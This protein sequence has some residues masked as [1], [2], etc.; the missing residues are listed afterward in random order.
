M[1][2]DFDIYRMFDSGAGSTNL[3]DDWR[4]IARGFHRNGVDMSYANKL[5]VYGDSSGRQVKVPTGRVW[6]DGFYGELTGEKTLAVTTNTSGST[7]YDWVV[8]RL[9]PTDN[10]V[11][12][13]VLVGT[14]NQ[15][16]PALTQS[17]TGIYEIALARLT[18]TNNYTTIAAADVLDT[19]PV[20]VGP[21]NSSPWQMIGRN[22]LASA[23]DT[24]SVTFPVRKFLKVVFYLI[25]T[26]G[27]IDPE[28]TVNGDG[29]GNYARRSS[30]NGAAEDT[31]TSDTNIDIFSSAVAEPSLG[32]LYISNFRT[33][34]KIITGHVVREGTSAASTSPDRMEIVAKWVTATEQIKSLSFTNGGGAGDYAIGSDVMVFGHD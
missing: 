30:I 31:A 21:S 33:Q 34:A 13:D 11:Q 6:V 23:G 27:T 9:N 2:T 3:E 26:G 18:L 32:V 8:A 1:A 16:T 15:D 17:A 28:F 12:L 22:T 19:R 20:Q 10:K 29:G 24:I 14:T 5:L 4:Q 7:R 25:D